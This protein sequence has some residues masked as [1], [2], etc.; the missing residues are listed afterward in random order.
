M[1]GIRNPYLNSTDAMFRTGRLRAS[2]SRVMAETALSVWPPL[3]PATVWRRAVPQP[4]WPLSDPGCRLYRWARQALFHGV[5]A[6]GLPPGA[7]VLVPAYHHG[8][9]V[10]AL[11][12]AGLRVRFYDLGADLTP[13]EASL[14]DALDD[15]AAALHLIHYIGRPQD[16]RRWRAW[17][18][19]RGLLLFEDAAQSWMASSAGIPV[20]AAGDLSIFCL[21]KS[22]GIPD[23]AALVGPS[24]DQA[25]DGGAGVA[26]ALLRTGA[27]MASRS[28]VVASA[29][30][31]RGRR[32]RRSTATD[33]R[34]GEIDSDMELELAPSAPSKASTWLLPRVVDE[35]AAARR[36]VNYRSLLEPL[37]ALVPEALRDVPEGAAP[38]VFPIA[39][40]RDKEA[41]FLRLRALRIDALHLWKNPH[42]LLDES[43]FPVPRRL[44]AT[45][46]GL[47]VH[48][49][50]RDADLDRIAAATTAALRAG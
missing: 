29:A 5:S 22:F 33:P 43:R 31:V 47:P 4:P 35:R 42:P 18:D 34:P 20:G 16:L 24:V 41:A 44:R 25:S 39:V 10:E 45:L 49:E 2:R 8:S 11:A 40:E 30:A 12:R 6:L 50:L 17:A 26:A 3:P 15:S 38:W 19:E 37:S 23:G 14:E 9:E 13:D 46:I 48:Q 36:R 7:T 27:W 28:V 1:P 32:R 21:Y